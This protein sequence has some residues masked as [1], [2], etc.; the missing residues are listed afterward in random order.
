MVNSANKA[1]ELRLLREMIRNFA[2][3]EIRPEIETMEK[4]EDVPIKLVQRMAELGFFGVCYDEKYG[5]SGFGKTGYCIVAEELFRA[6]GSTALLF[7]A[8]VSLA[9]GAVNIGGNEEQKMRY[10]KPAITGG[11][12]G[13]F[14]LTEPNAG[15][16]AAGVE[17]MAKKSGSHWILNG[18]KQFITN[19]DF[20]DFVV[21]IAQT[22]KL[23]GEKGLTAFI[24]ETDW[25]GFSVGK[26]EDKTGFRASHTV[27]LFFDN[28]KVSEENLL[29]TVGEGFKIAMK[30]LNGGRLG[31]GAGC[32]GAAKDA[33][34]QAFKY[35]SE[36][37]Q[38]GQPINKFQVNQFALAKMA[39]K[40]YLM[41]S[42]VYR[43][44]REIDAGKELRLEAAINKFMCSEMAW[45]IVDDAVQIFGGYGLI[46]DYS[47]ERIWRDVRYKRIF[48]GTN[49]I[50]Q[51]LI[52]KELLKSGG[53][54]RDYNF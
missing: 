44:A 29:G 12:I 26:H 46:K 2:N 13:A 30:T 4:T 6:H 21:V 9:C 19:G 25:P 11:K 41:E 18:Q 22:D 50:L 34:V 53:V 32:V 37:K 10:L 54:L 1:E 47:I 38:F 48:E 52:F 49:Q 8:H 27:Q 31:M 45:E 43:A 3:E 17:T 16:D 36:R 7:S 39:A 24:V 33:Y 5:G 28:L 40:I 42:A 15:S 14:A 20:A 51:L 35:A 23:L